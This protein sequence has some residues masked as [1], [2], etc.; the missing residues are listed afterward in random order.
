VIDGEKYSG[1]TT[2]YMAEGLDTGDIIDK[3]VVELKSDETGGS[4]FERLALTGGK[5]ILET[6]KKLEDGTAV[7]I[8]QDD[9]LSTYAGKITKELGKI[10][11]SKPAIEIERLIR[12]LNPWPSAFTMMD[13]KMM[14][15]WRADVELGKSHENPGAIVNASKDGIKVATGENYLIL[16]EIQLEGKKRMKVSDFINGY[17]INSNMLGI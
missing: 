10:D 1:V 2:M 9:D 6:L 16:K 15:I 4:L 8:A 7:R 11:F 13:G 14:K 17:S 12:G 5:L 3:T